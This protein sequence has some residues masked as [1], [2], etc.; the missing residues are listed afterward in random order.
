L[1][2][3]IV[4]EQLRLYPIEILDLSHRVK[5]RL[6]SHGIETLDD[7][8]KCDEERLLAIYHFGFKSLNQVKKKLQML[9]ECASINGKPSP[10]FIECL[11]LN[12]GNK[13]LIRSII[14]SVACYENQ[15]SLGFLITKIPPRSAYVLIER[16]G[17]KHEKKRTLQDIADILDITRER[18]R[19]LQERGM[20][21]VTQYANEQKVVLSW[22]QILV[23]AANAPPIS[24]SHF[25]E[26]VSESHICGKARPVGFVILATHLIFGTPIPALIKTAKRKKLFRFWKR[27]KSRQY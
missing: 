20:Y 4:L 5:S 25:L 6:K 18:V 22:R 1:P 21:W 26:R 11:K 9:N 15:N 16:F 14:E 7:L 2:R 8:S 10:D 24:E 3:F 12:M 19:Q 23:S 17:M 27:S 13:D